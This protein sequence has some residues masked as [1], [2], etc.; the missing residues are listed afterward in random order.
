MQVHI[1]CHT[2]VR[3]R[4]AEAHITVVSQPRLHK[5]RTAQLEPEPTIALISTHPQDKL[6]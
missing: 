4:R 6:S 2:L 3:F 1:T 5:Y